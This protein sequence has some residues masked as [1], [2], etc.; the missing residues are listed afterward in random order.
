MHIMIQKW[1][2]VDASK[3]AVTRL[4]SSNRGEERGCKGMHAVHEGGLTSH[5][6][7]CFGVVG[8]LE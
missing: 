4:V 2:G 3:E 6:G 1:L 8:K 5:D 7:C